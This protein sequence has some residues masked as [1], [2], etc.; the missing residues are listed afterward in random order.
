M[1]SEK[2]KI[3]TG[4]EGLW[5]LNLITGL[6]EDKPSDAR[7]DTEMYG[8]RGGDGVRIE[9]YSPRQIYK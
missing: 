4:E 1:K 6:W 9:T 3:D 7:A 8:D 2:S 5:D